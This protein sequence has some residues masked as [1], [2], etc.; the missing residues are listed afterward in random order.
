MTTEKAEALG[1]MRA[2]LP[3]YLKK[4]YPELTA[5]E[6]AAKAQGFLEVGEV[7]R[8]LKHGISPE[9]V[10]DEDNLF[11]PEEARAAARI[12][13]ARDD[14][15]EEDD[16]GMIVVGDEDDLSAAD[17]LAGEDEEEEEEEGG[18]PEED[19]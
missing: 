7:L 6:D 10:E 3:G 18:G 15:D 1:L 5:V 2:V 12:V 16:A 13:A 4:V 14:D 19:M 9:D 8:I 17:E 11:V